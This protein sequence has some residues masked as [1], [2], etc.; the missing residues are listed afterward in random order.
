MYSVHC[1]KYYANI[2]MYLSFFVM[3][4]NFSPLLSGALDRLRADP[5]AV[6]GTPLD[7]AGRVE[8]AIIRFCA[9]TPLNGCKF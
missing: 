9:A 1:K 3:P 6:A 7:E 8:K 5:P 4:G 2:R